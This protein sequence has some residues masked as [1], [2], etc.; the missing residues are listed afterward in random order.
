MAKMSA[1]TR[2]RNLAIGIEAEQLFVSTMIERGSEVV[3]SSRKQDIYDHIDF[4]VN[5]YGVDVKANRRLDKIWLELENVQ[6]KDGW[7]KG[8]ADYIA[9]HFSDI[10][11][12]M[13][14]RTEDL[15]EF[16]EENVS[17]TTTTPTEYM[18]WYTRSNWER[19]D[20]ITKVRY[21]DIEH[22]KHTKIYC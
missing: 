1:Y 2:A 22:L 19:K 16:V 11:C 21:E 14:F 20:L 13:I 7:L 5:G 4:F 12:F 6:G 8:K 15:L 17:E 9:F 10:N 3:K 18:K